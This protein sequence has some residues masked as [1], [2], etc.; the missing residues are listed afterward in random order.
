MRIKNKDTNNYSKVPLNDVGKKTHF[1]TTIQNENRM[2]ILW[3]HSN[4]QTWHSE[5]H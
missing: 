2:L 5:D 3:Y 1:P 4:K